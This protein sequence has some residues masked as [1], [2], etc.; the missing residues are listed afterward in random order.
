MAW[1]K[2]SMPVLSW[3]SSVSK[4]AETFNDQLHDVQS[5]KKI[6]R[7]GGEGGAAAILVY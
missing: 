3:M 6:G 1:I 2:L 5:E 4:N 7:G